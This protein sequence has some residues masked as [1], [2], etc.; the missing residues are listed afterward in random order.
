MM[1]DNSHGREKDYESFLKSEFKKFREDFDSYKKDTEEF[2]DSSNYL[3]NTLFL[4]Y[5]LN[6]PTFLLNSI[7][8]MSIELLNFVKNVCEKYDIT[9]W[10]DFGGLLGAR[11]HGGYIP[12]DDDMDIG[13]MRE[14]YLHFDNIISK[15]IQ[16][17]GLDNLL[18]VR[19][20]PFKP[21]ISKFIQVFVRGEVEISTFRYI[22]GNVDIFPYEY[23]RDYD[24]KII[25][26]KYK[27]AKNRLFYLKEKHFN[28]NY[29]LDKY[30]EDLNLSW[31]P[32]DHMIQGWE[33]PCTP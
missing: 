27:E 6:Q 33:S 5:E 2:I 10:L 30:Y 13:M 19:Y 29:V 26:D 22:L 20:R 21:G 31:E 15:E 16:N 1:K 32:T 11:R 7:Q 4:D 9:W 12:W 28:V 14:D 25:V 8:Q 17:Q 23:I 24:E 18:E 3:I